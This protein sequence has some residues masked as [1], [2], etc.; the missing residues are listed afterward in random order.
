LHPAK[1]I[2][3]GHKAPFHASGLHEVPYQGFK[4]TTEKTEPLARRSQKERKN[5]KERSVLE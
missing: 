2:V 1:Q 3:S 4:G 5:R